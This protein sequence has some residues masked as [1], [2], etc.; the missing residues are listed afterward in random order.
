MSKLDN[1]I[2]NKAKLLERF[3]ARG[4]RRGAERLPPGQRL[5]PGFPVLDLG[6]HPPFDPAAWRLRVEGLVA[7]P[8]EL[9]WEAFR[10]LPHTEQVS[11]FHCVTTWSR[12]DV[13]WSGVKLRTLL[14]R[15]RPTDAVT[16]VVQVC[17]DGYTTNLPFAHLQ[18]DDI[19]L[20]D[21]LEGEPLPVAHGGPLRLL[22]PHLYAWK[23]AK[24]LTGLR[25]QDHDT[26]GFWEER[27]YHAVGD[28]W[29]EERFAGA[30]PPEGWDPAE[31]DDLLRE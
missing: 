3:K 30:E 17:A 13:R 26:P 23:S 4:T 24:W 8:L 1:V 7:E 6:T 11:D 29:R 9:T 21:T 2:R 28:P 25:F 5:V 20:A 12:Y 10:A 14:E 18:G 22:V 16:H 15:V 19:L 31:V 27:G